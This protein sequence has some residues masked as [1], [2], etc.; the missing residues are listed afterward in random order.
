MSWFNLNYF[1]GESSN[2]NTSMFIP[3]SNSYNGRVNDDHAEEV[4]SSFPSHQ[5]ESLLLDLNEVSI[6]SLICIWGLLFVLVITDMG[7]WIM[8]TVMVPRLDKKTIAIIFSLVMRHTYNKMLVSI[9]TLKSH[10]VAS[11]SH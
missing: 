5:K 10:W 1:V 3:E 6:Y 4:V 8:D 9:L 2:D 11:K 7:F